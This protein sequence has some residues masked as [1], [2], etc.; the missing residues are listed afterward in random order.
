[1]KSDGVRFYQKKNLANELGWEDVSVS[2]ST[3]SVHQPPLL[4]VTKWVDEV[5][6][7]RSSRTQNVRAKRP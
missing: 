7:T 3:N 6:A 1:M 5:N 4:Y 2:S